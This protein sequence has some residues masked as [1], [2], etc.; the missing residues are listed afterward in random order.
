M[1]T[2]TT[3]PFRAAARLN[4][5]VRTRMKRLSLLTVLLLALQATSCAAPLPDFREF[6]DPR[7]TPEYKARVASGTTF[8]FFECP[9]LIFKEGRPKAGDTLLSALVKFQSDDFQD[10]YECLAIHTNTP[11]VRL[12]INGFSDPNECESDCQ[13]LSN[14]RADLVKETLLKMHF[15]SS[16]IVCAK[17][18]GEHLVLDVNDPERNRRVEIYSHMDDRTDNYNCEF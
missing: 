9:P 13:D 14:R 8:D 11:S 10:M 4:S 6:K 2:C 3:P 7:D 18:H 17:G 5:G 16:K 15:P 1:V 12:E